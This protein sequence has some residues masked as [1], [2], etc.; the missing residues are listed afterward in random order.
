MSTADGER[1]VRLVAVLLAPRCIR[2]APCVSAEMLETGG[3]FEGLLPPVAAA[4]AFAIR[5]PTV[6]MFTLDDYVAS[7]IMSADRA[8]TLRAAVVSRASGRLSTDSNGDVS[9]FRF[10]GQ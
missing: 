2:A 8:A 9:H 3:R 10:P 7:G 4:P 6:V 1:I 5:K